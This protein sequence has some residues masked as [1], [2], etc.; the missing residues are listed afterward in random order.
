[1]NNF[2]PW[3]VLIPE[4]S[5]RLAGGKRSATTGYE[6]Q[7]IQRSWKDRSI[8]KETFATTLSGSIVSGGIAALNHR[9]IAGTPPESKRQNASTRIGQNPVFSNHEFVHHLPLELYSFRGI[10]K[11]LVISFLS[12]RACSFPVR[13]VLCHT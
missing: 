7:R 1:M 5:Q 8:L 6:Y 4:G 2:L 10:Q 13:V 9:L 11:A 12:F 3:M